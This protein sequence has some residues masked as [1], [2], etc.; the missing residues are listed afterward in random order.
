MKR[1]VAPWRLR[2][3]WYLGIG[4][5]FAAPVAVPVFA[6]NQTAILFSEN[7][8]TGLTDR[9][10]EQG[11]PSITR[12]NAFS[13]AVEP[14]G[15]HYLNVESA[16]SYSAKGVRIAFSPEQCPH[17]SWRWNVSNVI[18][19]ADLSRK[20]GD[21]AAA[22]LY[23]VLAG[24]SVWKPFDKR[25]LVYL[26]D[27]RAPVGAIYP[28]AWLPEKERMVILESGATKV[29]QWVS[30][31]VN[32]LEDFKRAFPGEDPGKVEGVAFLADTDNT[33][34]EVS[35]GFDDLMIR[36]DEPNARTPR[37]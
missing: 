9:W 4:F 7:F 13:L 26:W 36:C 24:P 3:V 1:I 12:K 32:L 15:N 16:Q 21:D 28:N 14:N 29:G 5:L 27:N 37:K 20:E 25:I 17:L 33:R 6:S 11:F 18:E 34:S 19:A 2:P 35:A 30:E 31:R 10:V 8:E 22:K 23:V